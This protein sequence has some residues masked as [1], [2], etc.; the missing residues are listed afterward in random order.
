MCSNNYFPPVKLP[1]NQLRMK[2]RV[3]VAS[4]KRMTRHR[5][6]EKDEKRENLK[7]K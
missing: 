1:I 5:Q 7:V 3:S 6:E 4:R 2:E